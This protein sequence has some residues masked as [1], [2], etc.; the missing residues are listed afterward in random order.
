[1]LPQLYSIHDR[2]DTTETWINSLRSLSTMLPTAVGSGSKSTRS[3]R[4]VAVCRA[5]LATKNSSDTSLMLSSLIFKV[6]SLSTMEDDDPS[7]ASNVTINV[8]LS[9]SLSWEGKAVQRNFFCRKSTTG[10]NP[11]EFHACVIY[12]G[13]AGQNKTM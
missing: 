8:L 6:T 5:T 3:G 13:V 1:M 11:I 2:D 4:V 12:L 9:K 10:I 7:S